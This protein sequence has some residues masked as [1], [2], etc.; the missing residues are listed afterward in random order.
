MNEVKKNKK[1]VSGIYMIWNNVSRK[2]YIGSSINVYYRW[3]THKRL[4]SIGKHPNIKLQNTFN[5]H[6]GDTFE[7]FVLELVEDKNNLL[8]REQYWIDF[9]PP[10]FNIIR[11]VRKSSLGAKPKNEVLERLSIIRKGKKH[12]EEFKLKN[13][14]KGYVKRRGFEDS[15]MI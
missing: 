15:G 11:D 10:I 8:I 9:I 12:T 6:G 1:T 14:I 7:F 2:F 13:K 4:M 5:K 3:T